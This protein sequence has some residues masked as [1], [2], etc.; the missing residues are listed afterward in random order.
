MSENPPD[1]LDIHAD[2]S[3]DSFDLSD[4]NNVNDDINMLFGKTQLPVS[5]VQTRSSTKPTSASVSQ[6]VDIEIETGDARKKKGFT[7]KRKSPIEKGPTV[8]TPKRGGIAKSNL[9]K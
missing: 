7:K 6:N 1:I 4:G 3:D 5:Q 9:N 2:E 8:K